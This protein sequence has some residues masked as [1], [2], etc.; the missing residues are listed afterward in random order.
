MRDGRVG[1]TSRA[2]GRYNRAR[3]SR[4]PP[5]VN[6]SRLP[7][8]RAPG[9]EARLPWAMLTHHLGRDLPRERLGGRARAVPPRR[10][11]GSRRDPRGGGEPHRAH[12]H[13][14]GR[15]VGHG[16][17]RLGPDR[18]P[19]RAR[20]RRPHARRRAPG[21]RPLP[22]L[23]GSRAVAAPRRGGRWGFHGHRVRGGVGPRHRRAAR[24]G[25]RLGHHRTVAVDGGRRPARHAPRRSRGLARGHRGAGRHRARGRGRRLARGPGRRRRARRGRALTRESSR[26]RRSANR[27]TPPGEHDGAHL[28]RGGGGLPSDLSPDR[29]RDRDGGAGPRARAGRTGKPCGQPP[30]WR[31]RGPTRTAAARV[32]RRVHRDRGA[33]PPAHAVAPR[34][35]PVRGARLRVLVRERRGAP[36]ADGGALRGARR[37]ARRRPGPQHHDVEHRVAQR[38]GAR[39]LAGRPVRLRQ[40]GRPDGLGGRGWARSSPSPRGARG[41]ASRRSG[42]AQRARRRPPPRRRSPP[43]RCGGP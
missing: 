17:R 35:H 24:P 38:R 3:A 26:P 33:R 14:L 43:A 16:G 7:K 29:L 15:G 5:G 22:Q 6:D 13:Q 36:R 28:L 8:V 12:E 42:A 19:A 2:G 10:L 18:S 40:P 27:R 20:R 32:R 4:G 23:S 21:S 11:T 34:S 41:T 37:G 39:R 31:A 1:P 25:A 30:G 9:A